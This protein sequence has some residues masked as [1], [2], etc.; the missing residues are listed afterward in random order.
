[1]P[2]KHDAIIH[3]EKVTMQTLT[4]DRRLASR[5]LCLLYLAFFGSACRPSPASDPAVITIAVRSGP[6]TLDPRQG[7]DESSQRVSQL[8]FNSLMEWGDD[9][10]VHPALA[11]RLDNPDSLT[12]VAHLRRGITF[13]DGHELTARDVVYTFAA[14]H[15]PAFVS[16]LKGAYRLLRGVVA[17]D[18]YTVRFT[19]AEPFAAFPIQLVLPPVVPYGAGDA[20]RTSPI[21]T[22]PY[23]FVRYD[24]D[25]RVVL[26]AFDRFWK[27]PP[28]NAGLVV[29][30]IPDDTM[31][32]LELRKGA[33]DLVI[34]DLPPDIVHQLTEDGSF[35]VEPSPG[36][37]FSYIGFNLRDP[38]FADRRVRH[39]IGYAIDRDAII[40]HMRRGLARP[41][42][43]LLP[44]QAWAFEPA[45]HRFTHDPARARRLLDEAGYADPDGDGPQPRLR[46]SLKI[47]TNEETRL[48]STVVQEDLRRVGIDL[49]LRSY[50]FAT[51]FADV[52]KGNFQM[53]SLTWTGGSL[54]DP[55]ILRR[56]FH[57]NQ[58]PP[59]GFNR[60]YYRNAD[61]DRLLDRATQSTD[62][63]ERA[64]SY[65]DVQKL[66]A[67]DAP[68]IPIWNRTNVVVA[69]RSLD[70]LHLNAIGDFQALKEVK[71]QPQFIP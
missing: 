70:G 25:D 12:Y 54:V 8:I 22:G 6:T 42:S 67:E 10:R 47:S 71:R 55:D 58:T 50:E 49:D 26:E 18:D 30:V 3:N 66:V 33:T 65:R 16:P 31:R 21:G 20:M 23:R 60:G 19:L 51:F 52:L 63:D 24:T 61:V 32:G 56:V 37:D 36:L 15:D 9:L 5:A 35:R 40:R 17:L 7:T 13:H 27:G 69:Q 45:V 64:R 2:T 4:G 38:V 53:F 57:S 11:E 68:Y 41:A 46:L 44:D 14:F 62:E 48:Q 59:L 39:A 43:G 34:N 29:K 1:L 28:V